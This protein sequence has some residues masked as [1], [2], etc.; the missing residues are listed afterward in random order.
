MCL[1]R[2]SQLRLLGTGLALVSLSAC[3]DSRVG[4][5]EVGLSKDSTIKLLAMGA[6]AD[7]T[8][9]NLYRYNRYSVDSRYNDVFLFDPKN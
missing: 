9:P 1:S 8:L 5:L 7:D 3:G 4:Q 2:S 6:P